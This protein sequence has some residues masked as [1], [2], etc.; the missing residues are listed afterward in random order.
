MP[1][2]QAFFARQSAFGTRRL[3]GR[4]DR[5]IVYT[6]T[7]QGPKLGLRAEAVEGLFEGGCPTIGAADMATGLKQ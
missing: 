7:L 6:N 2:G 3:I 5:G 1:P 4:P